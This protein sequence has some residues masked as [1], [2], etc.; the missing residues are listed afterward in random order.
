DA[1][2][3]CSRGTGGRSDFTQPAW[4]MAGSPPRGGA[5]CLL[6]DAPPLN[7]ERTDSR[8]TSLGQ[9]RSRWGEPTRG[10][11]AAPT[12]LAEPSHF[13]HAGSAMLRY[14]ALV[15]AA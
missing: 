2:R 9:M 3:G 5:D 1:L 13:L 12:S 8:S 11:S 4:Q 6:K 15:L 10:Q 14:L 7:Q